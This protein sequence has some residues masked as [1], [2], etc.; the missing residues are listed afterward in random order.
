MPGLLDLMFDTNSGHSPQ[1]VAK[2]YQELRRNLAMDEGKDQNE[3]WDKLF[4]QERLQGASPAQANLD[5]DPQTHEYTGRQNQDMTPL[6]MSPTDRWK[7]QIDGLIESGNPVLQKQGL[8]MMDNY[9]QRV[10]AP[11]TDTRTSDIKNYQYDAANGYKGTFHEWLASHPKGTQ[12][13]IGDKGVTGAEWIVDAKGNHVVVPPNV[14][15]DWLA[16]HGLFFGRPPTADETKTT[17]AVDTAQEGLNR[18]QDLI[19]NKGADISGWQGLIKEWRAGSSIAGSIV[20]SV[21]SYAGNDLSDAD[22]QAITESAGL[23]NTILQAYRG[24]QVGP[25]EQ[26]MFNR[27]LP[28]P[29]QPKAVFK[30][31]ME[32]SQR[33]LAMLNSIKQGVRGNN[34][35]NTPEFQQMLKDDPEGAKAM[36]DFASSPEGQAAMMQYNRQISDENKK[37]GLSG[38]PRVGDTPTAINQQ[39]V[40]LPP[41]PPGHH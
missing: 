19:K 18:L 36:N 37:N 2:A 25:R 4:A 34:L 10:T 38:I 26:I 12:I 7:K 13:N 16:E 9:Q 14:D 33:N 3:Q 27:Q 6:E 17:A 23:S 20:N 40:A 35:M 24:A 41:P 30:A 29:G 32:R 11:A 21:L 22:V 5:V 15:R 28:V 31:N 39:G 1:E 8:A